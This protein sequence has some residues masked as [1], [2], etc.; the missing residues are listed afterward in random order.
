MKIINRNSMEKYE[1][2][3]MEQIDKKRIWNYDQNIPDLVVDDLIAELDIEDTDKNRDIIYSILL[4]RG[5]NKWLMVRKLL[6]RLKKL[7]KEDIKKCQNDLNLAKKS[8]NWNE[9]SK[10]KIKIKILY[11]IREQLKLLCQSPRWVIWNERKLGLIDTIGMPTNTA[12]NW[13]TFYNSLID[14]KFEC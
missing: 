14:H 5:I 9:Y 6:I 7:Y 10:I 2:R 11:K 4:K 13:F 1:R 12:V 3:T 8:K